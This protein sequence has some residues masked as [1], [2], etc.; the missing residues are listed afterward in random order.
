MTSVLTLQDDGLHQ[1]M[2]YALIT[3]S[4]AASI[5]GRV[6]LQIHASAPPVGRDQIVVF[7]FASKIVSIMAI[8][9]IPTLARKQLFES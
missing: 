4:V 9:P 5:M 2:K 7:L 1:K 8:A 6:S 3:L